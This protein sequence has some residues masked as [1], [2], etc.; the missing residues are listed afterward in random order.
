MCVCV[1]SVCMRASPVPSP[2]PK[3]HGARAEKLSRVRKGASE[4]F[5]YS[6]H[7]T[8]YPKCASV[9]DF[10]KYIHIHIRICI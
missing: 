1:Q 7:I 10:I 6:Y 2:S 4:L 5:C 3:N 8:D 9:G